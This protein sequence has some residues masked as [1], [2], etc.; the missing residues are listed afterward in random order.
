MAKVVEVFG[1]YWHSR[2]FT[3]KAPFEHEQQLIEAYAQAG[4][5]CL[6]VWEQEF[7]E[8]PDAVR[9]RVLNFLSAR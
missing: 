2:M 9:V 6:V 8:D 3:G 5:A 7:N 4:L 1:N